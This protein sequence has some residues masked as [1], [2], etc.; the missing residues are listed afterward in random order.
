MSVINSPFVILGKSQK[1]IIEPWIRD[2][3][4]AW[5]N[6]WKLEEPLDV[7]IYYSGHESRKINK[8]KYADDSTPN[9]EL[10]TRTVLDASSYPA[11]D[12]N[13]KP[14]ALEFE[15]NVFR[16]I[17]YEREWVNFLIESMHREKLISS[18]LSFAEKKPKKKHD[19]YETL[20]VD[21]LLDRLKMSLVSKFLGCDKPVKTPWK[22]IFAAKSFGKSGNGD[23]YVKVI[24]PDIIFLLLLPYDVYANRCLHR[25]DEIKSPINSDKGFEEKMFL[26]HFNDVSINFEVKMKAVELS[27][28]NM[29][30]LQKGDILKLELSLDEPLFLRVEDREIECSVYLGKSGDKRAIQIHDPSGS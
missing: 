25:S 12:V 11:P 15:N 20:I 4:V 1:N 7:E 14:T 21:R 8:A 9:I 26:P 17:S 24:L 13:E 16:N 3:I 27:L 30:S 10:L 18:V 23:I 5:C 19:E 22:E 2:S 28:D 29:E 6:Q